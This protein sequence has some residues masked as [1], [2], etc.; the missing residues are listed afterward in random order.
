[1][2]FPQSA[3]ARDWACTHRMRV[4]CKSPGREEGTLSSGMPLSRR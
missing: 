4:S 1:L 3:S 2:S